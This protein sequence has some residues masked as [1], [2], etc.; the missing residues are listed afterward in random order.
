MPARAPFTDQDIEQFRRHLDRARDYRRE[1]D[2][3]ERVG[4]DVGRYR[5]R[6]DEA[7]RKLQAVI[8]EYGDDSLP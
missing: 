6:L 2:R 7:E 3:A 1:L 4:V 8:H 5:E